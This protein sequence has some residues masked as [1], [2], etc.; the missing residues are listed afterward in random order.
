LLFWRQSNSL[1]EWLKNPVLR[2]HLA[3]HKFDSKTGNGLPPEQWELHY[4]VHPDQRLISDEEYSDILSILTAN[5]RQMGVSGK[6]YYL[7]GLVYCGTC[8][9]KMVLKN[10]QAHRYYG[11]RHG[12]ADCGNRK[13]IRTERL[14]EA[15]IAAIFQRA[16]LIPKSETVNFDKPENAPEV[17]EIRNKITDLKQLIEKYP[18]AQDFK[19]NLQTTRKE[20]KKILDQFGYLNFEKSSAEDIMRHPKVRQL[21]FWFALT[22]EEREIIYDKLGRC[23]INSVS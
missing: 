11:C 18:T 10:S 20:L 3:Y 23:C 13:N 6:I 8:G 2:G 15:I 7:T 12:A 9:A 21:A 16:L 1:I 5:G 14:D 4:D 19:Q 17:I 22:H